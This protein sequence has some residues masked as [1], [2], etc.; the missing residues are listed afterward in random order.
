MKAKRVVAL[1]VHACNP[2]FSE[3]TDQED[4]GSKLA[5]ANK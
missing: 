3:S 2:S 1:V 4:R 5:Q